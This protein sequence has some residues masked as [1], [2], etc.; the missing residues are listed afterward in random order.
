MR[1]FVHTIRDPRDNVAS[2]YDAGQKYADRWQ[3]RQTLDQCIQTYLQY[4]QK[5]EACLERDPQRHHFV[6]Y[7]NIIEHPEAQ[8]GALLN[9]AGL[10]QI[11]LDL[12]TIDSGS[13]ALSRDTEGWKK[14]RGPGIQDT[15]LI[16]YQKLFDAAQQR[17]VEEQTMDRYEKIV[18]QTAVR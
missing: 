5:S 18:T 4:L 14:E 6:V 3:G 15:R 10:K 13:A 16:K 1:T 7:E 2:L 17:Q 8:T 11:N 9:F 12:A